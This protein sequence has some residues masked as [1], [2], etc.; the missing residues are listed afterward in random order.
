MNRFV[1]FPSLFISDWKICLEIPFLQRS[2]HPFQWTTRKPE[3]QEQPEN[4]SDQV[5]DKLCS[6]QV[7]DNWLCV[8]E[9]FFSPVKLVT[10]D[11][12]RCFHQSNTSSK[13]VCDT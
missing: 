7:R 13:L 5:L 10:R 8:P 3:L 1:F 12:H 4:H 2:A 9:L 11:E 6:E